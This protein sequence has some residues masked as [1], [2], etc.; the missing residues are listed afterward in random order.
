MMQPWPFLTV[1]YTSWISCCVVANILYAVCYIF[2]YFVFVY[3]AAGGYS[4]IPS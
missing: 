2:I 4:Q 3:D 1:H